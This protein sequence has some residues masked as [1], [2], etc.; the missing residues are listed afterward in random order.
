MLF[1]P[2]IFIYIILMV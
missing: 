1:I 2:R